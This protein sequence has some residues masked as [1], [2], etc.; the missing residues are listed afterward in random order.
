MLWRSFFR[1]WSWPPVKRMA[2]YMNLLARICS[3]NDL[4][5]Q[6]VAKV[7]IRPIYYDCVHYYSSCSTSIL[8]T[9]VKD[10][11]KEAVFSVNTIHHK[12]RFWEHLACSPPAGSGWQGRVQAG[13]GSLGILRTK[14][15]LR[16][17]C[18]DTCSNVHTHTTNHPLCHPCW[19]LAMIHA[20][21]TVRG[22]RAPP[23][24][25]QRLLQRHKECIIWR[26]FL[27]TFWLTILFL[28]VWIG[29][30]T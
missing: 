20:Q 10:D 30:H 22:L 26:L 3:A 12:C 11:E 14:H 2:Q 25:L 13:D 18:N 24:P 1:L 21:T 8:S 23:M 4:N 19:S 5:N 27:F 7:G 29:Y 17:P 9:I 16:H 15:P 6:D 28:S